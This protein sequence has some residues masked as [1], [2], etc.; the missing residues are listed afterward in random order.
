MWQEYKKLKTTKTGSVLQLQSEASVKQVNENRH[1]F[2]AIAEVILVTVTQN[3]A[4]RGHRELNCDNHGNFKK[5]LHLV[6]KHDNIIP[7]R[8]FEGTVVTRYTSKDI[9]N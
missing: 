8:F 6:I 5:L 7:D 4:Q 1:Y 3:M 2:K 9:Q